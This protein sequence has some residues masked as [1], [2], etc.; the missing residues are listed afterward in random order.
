MYVIFVDIV[1]RSWVL[2]CN[3]FSSFL[4]RLSG[5]LVLFWFS[6]KFGI[7]LAMIYAIFVNIVVRSWVLLCN[8]FSSFLTRLSGSLIL[9]WF[10]IKFFF[11]LKNK[12]FNVISAI[13]VELFWFRSHE[14]MKKYCCNNS[15]NLDH[16]IKKNF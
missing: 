1:V 16:L 8:H 3:H 2:L 5:N 12:V 7:V 6:M 11:F 15:F 9:F 14:I 10:S 13:F 4:I